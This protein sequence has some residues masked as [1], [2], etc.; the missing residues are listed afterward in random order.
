M[1]IPNYLI[2]NSKFRNQEVPL[3]LILGSLT[4][5]DRCLLVNMECT[6]LF[7]CLFVCVCIM[8]ICIYITRFYVLMIKLRSWFTWK[9]PLQFAMFVCF[10]ENEILRRNRLDLLIFNT[11]V[12]EQNFDMYVTCY[13]DFVVCFTNCGML[14]ESRGP[15]WRCW[16]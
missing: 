14:S 15:S 10:N 3:L 12:S 5:A 1:W 13:V 9:F 4:S 11:L 16:N 8:Y 6:V 2:T 7:V